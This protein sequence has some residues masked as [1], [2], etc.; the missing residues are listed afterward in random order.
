MEITQS[1][2]LVSFKILSESS[3]VLFQEL[4]SGPLRGKKCAGAKPF[5]GLLSNTSHI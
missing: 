2:A 4:L 1:F 5:L 3:F